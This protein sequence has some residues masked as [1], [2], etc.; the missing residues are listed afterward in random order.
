MLYNRVKYLVL[1]V[2]YN[3]NKRFVCFND[4]ATEGREHDAEFIQ[5]FFS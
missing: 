4:E 3:D 2:W 1:F 5:S